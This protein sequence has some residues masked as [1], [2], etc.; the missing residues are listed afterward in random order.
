M[1]RFNK[2]FRFLLCVIGIY[3]KY[4]WVVPLKGKKCVT[5]VR[6]FQNIINT[7]KRKPNEI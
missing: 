4:V 7:L 5:I 3:R 1:S 6:A 2:G